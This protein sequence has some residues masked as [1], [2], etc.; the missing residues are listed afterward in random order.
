MY[1]NSCVVWP[2]AHDSPHPLVTST[3]TGAYNSGACRNTSQFIV[4]YI[5]PFV[6]WYE[7]S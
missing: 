5:L 6:F 7:S 1:K 4:I 3:L 2:L